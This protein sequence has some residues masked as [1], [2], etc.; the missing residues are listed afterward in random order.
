MQH[1]FIASTRRL[2]LYLLFNICGALLQ[3]LLNVITEFICLW[4]CKQQHFFFKL[5]WYAGLTYYINVDFK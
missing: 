2:V 1:V 4:Q 3:H 5:V